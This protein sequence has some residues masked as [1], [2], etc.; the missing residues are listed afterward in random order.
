MR[1][2]IGCDLV[3]VKNFKKSLDRGGRRFLAR[4]FTPQE[5]AS[6]RRTETLAGIFA[7]KE[8]ILKALEL[9]PGAWLNIEIQKEPNGRP[10][11]RVLGF[12]KKILDRD[13]SISHDGAYSMAVAAFLLE[14]E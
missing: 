4:C 5:L 7:A 13:L 11:A 9:G 6:S 2:K 12:S 8:A 3:D 1:V 10:T 14:K